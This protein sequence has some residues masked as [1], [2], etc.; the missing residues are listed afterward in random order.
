MSSLFLSMYQFVG[1]IMGVAIRGH[2]YLNLD[3]SSVVWKP[4]VGEKITRR[5][6][7]VRFTMWIRD[8]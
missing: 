3:F 8:H 6:L 5:D 1:K 7:Q 4:L 2:H